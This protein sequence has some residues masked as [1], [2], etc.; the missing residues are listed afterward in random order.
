L[1]SRVVNR[2]RQR[3]FTEHG[4]VEAEPRRRF[5]C[6]DWRV[7]AVILYYELLARPGLCFRSAKQARK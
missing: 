6:R 5:P 2:Q 4:N 7:F 1:S 3:L